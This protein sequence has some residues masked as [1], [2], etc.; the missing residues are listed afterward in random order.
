MALATEL[1]MGEPSVCIAI[2][3]GIGDFLVIAR[4]MRDFLGRAEAPQFDVYSPSPGLASWAFSK[5]PGFRSSMHDLL[6]ER[7]KTFYDLSLRINQFV[8][9]H[10]DY[11]NWPKLRRQADFVRS[12]DSIIRYRPKLDPFVEVHPY[13]DNFLALRAVF[14]NTSRRNFLHHIAGCSYGGDKLPLKVDAGIVKRAGLGQARYVTVHNG[15]DAAFVMSGDW[16]TKCYPHFAAVIATL[17]EQTPDMKFVQI[18]TVTSKPIEGVD[19]DLVGQ[20]SLEEVSGLIAG[21]VMHIDNE[22]G[23]VHMAACLGV[24]SCVVFGPTPSNYFGYPANINIDPMVCGGCWWIKETWMDAC[25]RG[26]GIARCMSEQPPE[27]IA[28]RIAP[29]LVQVREAVPVL[30]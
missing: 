9:V 5:V 23:L 10:W 13:M 16:A 19:I 3:G 29:L 28:A 1:A 22:G 25:P 15:F 30:D 26:F 4:F 14:N 24:R 2:S 20:T 6:F 7:Y 21:A 12:I 17:R 11:A 18:G 8:V 27:R